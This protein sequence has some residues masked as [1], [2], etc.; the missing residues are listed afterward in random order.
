[1]LLVWWVRHL[2]LIRVISVL[3][4]CTVVRFYG[5]EMKIGIHAGPILIE[6]SET[7]LR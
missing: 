4:V 6:V 3:F 1:M 5:N 7:G 2:Y